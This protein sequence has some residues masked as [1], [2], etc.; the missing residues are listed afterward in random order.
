MATPATFDLPRRNGRK[1]F[2][3]PA[4]FP[5]PDSEAII[6][7]AA[8][9]FAC[10]T[11]ADYWI[12]RYNEI[13]R[14]FHT[15]EYN[16]FKFS[17]GITGLGCEIRPDE[18]DAL[19][20]EGPTPDRSNEYHHD[21]PIEAFPEKTH[22]KTLAELRNEIGEPCGWICVYCQ[23]SGDAEAGPD[24]RQWHIDHLYARSRGGDDEPDNLVLSCATC[25]LQKSAKLLRDAM[26]A[27]GVPVCQR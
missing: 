6:N 3:N 1:Q 23:K 17:Y 16:Q 22:R 5:P 11:E 15:H 2:F 25:N 7:L 21:R 13:V 8:D 10:L 12:D 24:K 4:L 20:Q 19:L 14:E 9:A 18:V 26:A 27:K